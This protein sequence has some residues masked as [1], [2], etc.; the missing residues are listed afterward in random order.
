MVIKKDLINLPK[1]KTRKISLPLFLEGTNGKGVLI[2]HG[3]TGS[4]HD[5]TYMAHEINKAGFT[6]S[7][8]RLPGHGISNVDFLKT[9]SHDWLRRAI[10]AYYD[11]SALC[12]EVYVV[13]LSMG[14]VLALI[15]SSMFQP[16]KLVTLAA[17]THV[18]DNRIK[19]T[20]ILRLF[21]DRIPR[22]NNDKY[23][24]ED[25]EYL[26]KEYWSFNWPKQAYELYKL[27]KLSRKVT[28]KIT[29]DT[30]VMV[31][32]N[33]QTVPVSAGEFIYKTIASQN[34]KLVVLEKSGHVLS[35]DCEKER[36]TQ[37]V[38]EWLLK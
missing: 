15:V 26:K 19:L 29:S 2:I 28:P 4:P 38:I 32:K 7:L 35:N 11:L 22:E 5:F 8:P 1:L 10:D 37:E 31:S 3:Y 9:D 14:G 12:D 16:K 13:G 30:L 20:G 25:L 23:D 33:D 6:V 34:R 24:S 27:M 21:K 17:A 36:V 18:H